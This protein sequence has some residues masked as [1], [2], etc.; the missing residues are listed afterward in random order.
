MIPGGGLDMDKVISLSHQ[1]KS[2]VSVLQAVWNWEELICKPKN[3]AAFHS[4]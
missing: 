4:Q 2:S 1:L 3:P